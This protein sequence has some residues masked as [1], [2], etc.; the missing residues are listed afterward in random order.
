MEPGFNQLG[1]AL[2]QGRREIHGPEW[3]GFRSLVSGVRTRIM[4][5]CNT[6]AL[7]NPRSPKSAVLNGFGALRVTHFSIQRP[8]PPCLDIHMHVH[9]GTNS[10]ADPIAV[11]Q[12]STL[13]P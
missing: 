7:I 8:R 3:F 1:Y 2:E 12:D 11:L 6:E 13:T 10:P 5:A 4:N 9:Q